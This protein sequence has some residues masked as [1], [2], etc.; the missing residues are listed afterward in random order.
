MRRVIVHLDADAF[1]ASVEQA[2]DPR[3]R[4]KPVAVGG[5][6]RGVIASASYEARRMGI[7]T[8]MPT[9]LARKLCPGLIVLPGDFDKYEQFSRWMFSYAQDFTPDVEIVSIDE[10]Y[11]DLTSVRKLP[12]LHVAAT[13]RNAIRQALKISVSEGIASNKLVSQVAS[14]VKKPGAFVHIPA[15]ME[16]RFLE[17]LP[18]KW[19]PGVGEKTEQRLR[20]AG[21][22]LIG[23]IAAAPLEMLQ[24]IF[25]KQAP[26]IKEFANGIDERPVVSVCA[27]AKSYSKQHTFDE[28]ITD[29]QY[30]EA[31]VCRMADQLMETV[32][33][34]GKAIRT[35]ALRVR[36]NDMDEDSCAESLS[37]PTNLEMDIYPRLRTMLKKVWR[38]RVSLRMVSVKFSNVYE[39][40]FSPGLPMEN[41]VD[42]EEALRR[43]ASAIDRL[44][45]VYGTNAVMR[46]H[47][48]RLLTPPRQITSAAAL[49]KPMEKTLPSPQASPK[50]Q[51]QVRIFIPQNLNRANYAPLNIYSHYSFLQSTLSIDE[52]I[53]LAQKYEI[54]SLAIAD[55]ANLHGAVEFFQKAKK[56]GIKP[57]IGARVRVDKKPVWLYVE[58][59]RGY[60]NLCELLSLPPGKNEYETL[61]S[62]SSSYPS[63]D[64]GDGESNGY[65]PQFQ[66]AYQ[67]RDFKISDIERFSDGLVIVGNHPELSRFSNQFYPAVSK[68]D[69]RDATVAKKNA[70]AV[71]QVCYGTAAERW[72]F[73]VVQSIR[74]RTMVGQTHPDK[75]PAGDYHFPSPAEVDGWFKTAPQLLANGIEIARR[76]NFELPLGKLRL[77]GFTPPDG[78]S[79]LEFLRRLA[80]EGIKRRYGGRPVETIARAQIE[81]E[82][83]IIAQVGY[84]DY[85]L[86]VWDLLQECRRRGI[87]WLTRGSAAD[88]LVC[89]CL[90]I[91]N[92]CPIRFNLYF[93]RFLNRERMAFNKLPDIDIDFPH[94][95]KDD[96]IKLIFEKYGGDYVAIVGGFST[97]QARS[98]VGEVGKALGLS[99]RQI[100]QITANFP[101]GGARGL[102]SAIEKISECK[103]LPLNEEPYKSAIEMAEFLDGVPRYPKMH[104]CGVT[105]A[106][107]PVR[108]LTPTFLSAKGYPTSHYD[109][110]SLEAL[111]LVKIDIL[112]QGGLAVIRDVLNGLEKTGERIELQNLEPW[113]EP[114]VWTMIANGETRALHHIESPAM[115][116]LCRMTNVRDIDGLVA[117]VSVIRPGAANEQ[118]KLKFTR[119][120][121]GLEKPSYP[122]PSLEPILKETFGI[123]VYEEHVLQICEAFAGLP[124]GRADT[125]RRALGK[126]K[127]KIV[128]EIREEF[129]DSA[130]AR[131]RAE[132]EIKDVWE[133][134]EGFCGYAFCKAHS[135]AYAVEAYQAAWLKKHY[136]AHFM[137]AVLSNGKGFY[138]P[139]VYALECYRLG[140]KFIPPDINHPGV[141]FEARKID[142]SAENRCATQQEKTPSQSATS[143][144][145]WAICV[146]AIRAKGLSE[147]TIR[148]IFAERKAGEFKSIQDFVLRVNPEPS[149]MEILIQVGAFDPFGK[150]RVEQ[151]WEYQRLY[152]AANPARESGQLWLFEPLQ[153]TVGN[154]NPDDNGDKSRTNIASV[155]LEEPSFKQKLQWEFELLGFTASAHP[156][157]LWDDIDW[158]TYCPIN[159]LGKYPGEVVVTCGLVIEQRLHQQTG[160]E[161]MKFLSL[162]DW[163]GIVETELFAPEYKSYGLATARYPVL[164]ITARV[165]PF[166][167]R[168]GFSLRILRA[169][170]PRKKQP[171]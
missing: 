71:F 12:P 8:P 6:R 76:C 159:E 143:S 88:S 126:G 133:M 119:C 55:D 151:F 2:S 142:D 63:D 147:L 61:F 34:E 122:H 100:R 137:A 30:I 69:L 20:S 87:E 134:I 109:M 26:N 47:D 145:G 36:Y 167:N 79:S 139:L 11:F 101:W 90:G 86:I 93:R 57:I 83:K 148:R 5:E 75:L 62:L 29:E 54:E 118:K 106:P 16:K 99:E 127:L 150:K 39:A 95:R 84:E 144:G 24:I 165:E 102:K 146:P 104:P 37:E 41:G 78:S 18:G 166:E 130:R 44:R 116:G 114:Q 31:T 58:N 42:K 22:V 121:Q 136:P 157:A 40:I 80:M 43:L 38:R 128:E 135:A 9:S 131:G 171:N 168:R 46:G 45:K 60:S 107:Q 73:N 162:A 52:I 17:P 92:V 59:A 50:S 48:L 161:P 89:Y 132:K 164:E 170:E 27:P 56:A 13:I 154:N 35:I 4:G 103:D 158:K 23:Q 115:V 153:L 32:R 105:V 141:D 140:I 112:A 125:L 51:C 111:G 1:F 160:G 129:F 120:Y 113:E 68:D 7:Y 15:G 28:D 85:F 14:K 19:L 123:V 74:A 149:E 138:D 81:E 108:S 49:E 163:T 94:D 110:D 21:L 72:K 33:A 152:A 82:L 70:V 91:S 155:H 96:V 53:A 64:E 98:A 3:L 25:G 124:P 66:K 117:I 77:P 10:G 169:G 67:K 156:L 97:F 65:Q